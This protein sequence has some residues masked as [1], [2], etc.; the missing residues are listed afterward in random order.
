MVECN[1]ISD[2]AT[3]NAVNLIGY[4]FANLIIGVGES[5]TLSLDEGM[6]SGLDGIT[7]QVEGEYGIGNQINQTIEVDF[8]AGE[9]TKIKLV[10][11]DTACELK[12]T[13]L[14]LDE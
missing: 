9:V 8:Q 14:K 5:V 10:T 1:Q 4:E 11:T 12:G 3:I 13:I 7:I 2:L 6:P